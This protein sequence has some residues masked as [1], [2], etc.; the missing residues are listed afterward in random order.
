M[1]NSFFN[2]HHFDSISWQQN[3][4]TGVSETC[5]TIKCFFSGQCVFRK[6][7]FELHSEHG[8][9]GKPLYATSA[10][11]YPSD[12]EWTSMFWNE[13][14]LCFLIEE[15]LDIGIQKH[16]SSHPGVNLSGWCLCL[17]WCMAEK[18]QRKIALSSFFFWINRNGLKESRLMPVSITSRK[19]HRTLLFVLAAVFGSYE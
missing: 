17:Y 19:W 18:Y 4:V 9:S 7:I 8:K 3:L 11:Y 14:S 16:S 12:R 10:I 6:L 5:I 2:L 1:T 15:N 13:V